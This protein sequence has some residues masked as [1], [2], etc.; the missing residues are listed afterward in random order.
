MDLLFG[1][2]KSALNI[3]DT[4]TSFY[5]DTFLESNG[6]TCGQIV[7]ACSKNLEWTGVPYI[8]A[9]QT[10]LAQIND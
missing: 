9:M 3:V 5:G 7:N 1:N 10:A 2:D 4:A 6:K 8:L